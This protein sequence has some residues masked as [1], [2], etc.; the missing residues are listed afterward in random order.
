MNSIHCLTD[1]Q[2]DCDISPDLALVRMAGVGRKPTEAKFSIYLTAADGVAATD[3][4][5]TIFLSVFILVL[6]ARG[7]V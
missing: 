3:P 1:C 7:A 6:L 2:W 4:E 5:R